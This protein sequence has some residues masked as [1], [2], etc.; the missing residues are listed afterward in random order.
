MVEA[1]KKHTI[2]DPFD[3]KTFQGPQVSER[4]QKRILDYIESGKAEG[5]KVEVGGGAWTQGP[6][7][8]A[9]GFYV[10][11]TIFSGVTPSMKIVQEEIFGPVLAVASFKTEEE[12]IKLA[13]DTSYGLGAGV[14]SQNASRCMRVSGAIQAG[15]VWVNQYV[16]VSN[17][18][19]FGGF[20]SSGIGRE[21]GVDAIKEYTQVKSIH[22]NYGEQLD[23]PISGE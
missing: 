7:E 5:A 13:N 15:T 1:F 12:A 16:V 17:A 10:Q 6:G 19:P 4:H 9:N 18:V 22:W 3:S 20:K 23:W 8:F 11:P 14:F 2:G 21:L